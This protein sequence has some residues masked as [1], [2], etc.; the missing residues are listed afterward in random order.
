MNPPKMRKLTKSEK[1]DLQMYNIIEMKEET[2]GAAL[3][4]SSA[5]E[6]VNSAQMPDSIETTDV[7]PFVPDYKHLM[8]RNLMIYTFSN[9]DDL[10]NYQVEMISNNQIRGL[11]KVDYTRINGKVC[12]QYD[13]TSLVPLRKLFERRKINR[14]DFIFII[15]QIVDLIDNLEQY[16]LDSGGIVFD[17]Q[18]VFA[19]PQDLKL[20][21]TYL[22]TMKMSY[23]LKGLKAF[24]LKLVVNDIN[25]ADEPSDNYVRKLIEALKAKDFTLSSLKDYLAQINNIESVSQ[26]ETKKLRTG[27]RSGRILSST[28]MDD[29]K[30][31]QKEFDTSLFPERSKE[32]R[33]NIHPD[34][35]ANKK[36]NL[37]SEGLTQKSIE[38]QSELKTATKLCYPP[39][40][41]IILFSAI[42]VLIIFGVV[43]IVSG[44]LSPANPDFL[45]SLFGFVLIGGAIIYLIYSKLFTF[46][47]KVERT[48]VKKRVNV[49]PSEDNFAYKGFS[50]PIRPQ[51]R[52]V[53]RGIP[54]V[55]EGKVHRTN[56]N[57]PTRNLCEKKRDA[58]PQEGTVLLNAGSLKVPHLKRIV[59][60]ASETILLKS[61]PFMIGRLE[62]QVDYCLKNP[63]IGKL[64][65][66]VLKT[67]EGYF[68]CDINSKNG[69]FING[70]RICPGKENIVQNEDHI[71]LGNEEFIFCEG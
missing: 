57:Y 52:N 38:N 54:E 49:T 47:N 18:L 25:F 6:S 22:P 5:F 8:S 41:Y 20:G 43:L 29:I 32:P 28:Q 42:G 7:A 19:D 21:F 59:D 58:T 36:Q 46:D 53:Q 10:I 34:N 40:S 61:F 30:L 2:E 68:I 71:T 66:E 48:I 51:N 4:S 67:S 44:V 3:K 9:E 33:T 37:L 55:R 27:N 63:A 70:E 23:G 35:N 65:A 17:S 15:K 24:L 11:L 56:N 13:V 62:G 31:A 1:G 16:L 12:L 26:G 39:K 69:T 50:V 60:N 64:H 45:L 14:D